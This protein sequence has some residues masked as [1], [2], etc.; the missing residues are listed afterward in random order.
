MAEEEDP[1]PAMQQERA[2]HGLPSVD[3]TDGNDED[4]TS[5]TGPLVGPSAATGRGT[6]EAKDNGGGGNCDEEDQSSQ[7]SFV[8]LPHSS[9]ASIEVSERSFSGVQRNNQEM[10]AAVGAGMLDD[11]GA[12]PA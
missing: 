6:T 12:A 1:K 2:E 9:R 8:P 10:N 5:S 3:A 4:G 11:L 7:L